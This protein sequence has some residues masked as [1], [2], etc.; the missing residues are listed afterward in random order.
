M[1]R[2]SLAAAALSAMVGCAAPQAGADASAGGRDCFRTVEVSGYD[3]VDEH[4]VSVAINSRR[5]YILTIRENTRALDWTNA[6]TLRS[7]SNFVCVGSGDGAQLVG[8]NTALFYRV[9]RVER[10]PE[11]APAGS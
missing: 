5:E 6:V 7:P 2:I 4:R 10:A 3:I 8:G 9:V 1:H 11:P